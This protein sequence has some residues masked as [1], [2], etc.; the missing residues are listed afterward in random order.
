[1]VNPKQV[2]VKLTCCERVTERRTADV[3]QERRAAQLA[4]TQ[5]VGTSA[6]TVRN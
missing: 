1:M 5:A 2:N 3:L 4:T 6:T